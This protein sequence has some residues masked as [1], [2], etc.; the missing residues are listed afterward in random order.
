MYEQICSNRRAS[1]LLMIVVVAIL[2]ALGYVIG[3]AYT[4]TNDG[5]LGF[6]GLFGIIAIAVRV[7]EGVQPFDAVALLTDPAAWS[8]A[9]AGASGFYVQTVALQVGA[10]NGVTAVLVVGDA[11]IDRSNAKVKG[12]SKEQFAEMERLTAELNETLKA[13]FEQGDP[14]GALAQRACALHREWLCFFWDQYSKE[15]HMGVAQMYVDDPRFTAY[16]DRIAVGCAQFLRDAV[17]IYCK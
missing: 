10:V 17:F 7:L 4:G 3:A 5:G 16:Y 13:A 14:A 6:L 15:A 9:V 11:Q 1:W 8:I 12:M 2:A